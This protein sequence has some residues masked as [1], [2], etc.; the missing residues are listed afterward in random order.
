[1]NEWIRTGMNEWQ[2]HD[3]WINKWMKNN[4]LEL[5]WMNDSVM[6]RERINEWMNSNWNEWM[7]VSGHVDKTS[8]WINEWIRTNE[9]QCR[10]V[11]EIHFLT[12]LQY[13]YTYQQKYDQTRE[14]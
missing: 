13:V 12:L 8:E 2:C 9:G 7:T 3:M 6:T 4:E 14:K 5:E 10:A 1:M 11:G